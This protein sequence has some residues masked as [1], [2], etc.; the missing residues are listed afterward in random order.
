MLGGFWAVVNETP[1]SM[2]G[3]AAPMSVLKIL[4][5]ED[6]RLDAS[7]TEATLVADGLEADILR[8]DTRDAF[9]AALE[10]DR[11]DV[12]I[13][14][15]NL[16]VFDGLS[17]QIL[18]GKL[19]PEIPFIFLSGS[20]GEET[21]VERLKD[22]ATD[23]VLKDRMA[24]LPAAIR[25]ALAEAAERTER[26]RAE[27]EIHR[28]NAALEQRVV[29]RTA[30]LERANDALAV[31]EIEL[32]DA[33]V[34][35]EDLIAASPSMIFRLD[36]VT[37]DVLY[38]S[39][40]VGSL[41]GFAAEELVGLPA[42]WANHIHPDDRARVAAEVDAALE[43]KVVQIE[44][45]YRLCSKDDRYRWFF[46]LMR[47]EYDAEMR[48]ATILRYCLDIADRKQA[49]DAR[50]ES[51]RRLQAILDHSPPVSLKDPSGRYLLTNREFDRVTGYSTEAIVGRTDD[52]L[53]PKYLANAY[54]ANDQRVLDKNGGLEVE[55]IILDH[56]E[57]R[58]FQ[59]IKFPLL[60][61]AN[62]PYALCAVSIDIT[63]R[64]KANDALKI[65]QLEA[66]RAN[67]AK[68]DFLSR[69]SH[70]LRTPLNAILGF[71]QLLEV[72]DISEN[73]K[74][75]VDHILRG[76]QHLL[77]LINEV[78]DIARIE[79]GHLSL[80]P[81]PVH[82]R[83]LVELAIDLVRPLAAQ[84]GISL[85]LED[86]PAEIVV[87]ADRQRFNQILLNLLSNAVKYNRADG[88][89]TVSF[90]PAGV[91]RVRIAVTDT[92]AGI[93]AAKLELLFQPFER[94]GAER[95]AVEGT[96]LG[97]AL[98][99]GLAEA[100]G[101]TLGVASVLIRGPRSG[102][103]WLS[104]RGRGFAP[105]RVVDAFPLNR[106]PHPGRQGSPCTSR[107]TVPTCG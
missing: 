82:A 86:T 11:F 47:V 85:V 55:E 98:S 6:N 60:D 16:P 10:S 87:L 52:D 3:Y 105:R 99:R 91:D 48:P 23:Y 27:D 33:K 54:R 100:M 4:H 66:N 62:R 20:I 38:A 76:G 59:S 12:I 56:G 97:L 39:P 64:K 77:A 107:T 67:H 31:R 81:E 29:E 83:E 53:F 89:V 90:Q 26:R 44:Q 80:S 73:S 92:G 22:G 25:R 79:A 61:A 95:T 2:V 74:E 24:R 51:E 65:A 63:E 49:E 78:L 36:P 75:S 17:A 7:L 88:R 13:A 32:R 42:F 58:T 34:F 94:L 15:Y 28:L 106:R 5:L 40:N 84:R 45:E 104:P 37:F 71:A 9:S 57:P 30:A 68:S 102:S 21:A 43:A 96:G 14:D 70:D 18:A 69:M 1:P 50:A 46:S 8:V 19:R 93:S 103:N 72:D 35:L 101:G 41:L